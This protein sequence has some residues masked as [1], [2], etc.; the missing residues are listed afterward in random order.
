MQV[1][2]HSQPG[3]RAYL[4]EYLKKVFDRV[5]QADT[6]VTRLN[7]RSFIQLGNLSLFLPYSFE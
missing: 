2:Q 6:G 1:M 4:V 3:V 5:R 7:K